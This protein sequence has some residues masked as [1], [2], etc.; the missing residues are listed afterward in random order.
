M[1]NKNKFSILAVI[2]IAVIGSVYFTSTLDSN[3][4]NTTN[5]KDNQNEILVFNSYTTTDLTEMKH[6][7]DAVVKGKIVDKYQVIQY[8]DEFGN[9][10]KEDSPKIAQTQPYR[11]YE[12][13][14]TDNIKSSSSTNLYKFKVLGGALNEFTVVSEIPEYQ[15]GDNLVI[16][17]HAPF[18]GEYFEPVSGEYGIYKLEQGKAIS[19]VNT[20]S[21]SSL[22]EILR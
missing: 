18:D 14:V 20:I 7:A 12:L 15:I 8:R 4:V 17:L 1:K 3:N 5:L 22:L 21:E 13:Q 2:T 19:H 6:M 11:V 16:L 10:V 9:Y